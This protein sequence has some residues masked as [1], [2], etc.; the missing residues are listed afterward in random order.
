M[1]DGVKGLYSAFGK[2]FSHIIPYSFPFRT[3]PPYKAPEIT[4]V[5][6]MNKMAKLMDDNIID[7]LHIKIGN[8]YIDRYLSVRRASSPAAFQMLYAN[9]FG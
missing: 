3:V 8:V 7:A 6:H 4:A 5:V 2:L 9:A 1:I